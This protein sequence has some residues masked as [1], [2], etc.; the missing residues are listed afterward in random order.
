[1]LKIWAKTLLDDKI[2]RQT[3]YKRFE[4]FDAES[5]MDYLV[6][7]C[8]ELDV[9]TPVVLKRHESDFDAFRF[10]KFRP[11]DFVESVDFELLW[12]ENASD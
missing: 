7:I 6:E 3:M 11:G 8:H 10:V 9:P 4:K 1:M 2:T 5:F 12:L